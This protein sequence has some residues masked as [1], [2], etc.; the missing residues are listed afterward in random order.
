MAFKGSGPG[1]TGSGVRPLEQRLAENAARQ[2]RRAGAVAPV[3]EEEKEPPTAAEIAAEMAKL[4]GLEREEAERKARN[5]A[6]ARLNTVLADYGL[7]TLGASVQSWLIEGLSEAEIVQR[8]RETTEYKTRFPAIE[9]RK[10]AGL[11][12]ISEGE[13]VAYER[14]ARQLMR[15]AGLP[16]GFYDG[17]EDFTKFLTNDLSLAELGDRVTLAANAA[18]NMPKE[19]RDALTQWGMGPGDLTAF[20]LDPDKAQPLLE[21]KYNASLLAGASTR[22]Q[23]ASLTEDTANQLVGWGTTEQEAEQGFG[24]LA[25]SKELFQTLDST[26]D[27]I[28]QDEQVGAA[29]GGNSAARR[30]IEQR[31]AKRTA[32]FQAGGG[33]ASSQ[34][35]L[36][37]LGDSADL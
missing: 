30:R 26:E 6:Y 24:A 11:A 25:D 17:Q 18:F 9:A 29:F 1:A 3:V 31:R 4:Q 14:N 36:A 10:K 7:G 21:R 37:G 34:S 5:D 8:M 20:W 33:F 19:A 16:Q 32:S 28:G 12:P 27:V 13:Y 2:A 22:A 15:A 35:G 23:Y